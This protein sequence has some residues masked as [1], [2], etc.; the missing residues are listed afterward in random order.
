MPTMS[1]NCPLCQN[2]LDADLS[3]A[4][5]TV[6]CPKCLK[7]IKVPAPSTHVS[8]QPNYAAQPTT[9]AAAIWSLVLGII[10]W[11][12]CGCFGLPLAIAAVTCGH[13]GLSKI[14][15]SGGTI[16]GEGLC[17]AGLVL[18]YLGLLGSLVGCVFQVIWIIAL[19]AEGGF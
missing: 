12:C 15:S 6:Q 9:S 17:I 18:G 8:A 16:G 5:Q 19:I 3:V 13:S 14:R 10:S 7:L 11:V 1:F 4:G 2:N